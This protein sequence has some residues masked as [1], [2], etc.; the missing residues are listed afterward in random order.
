MASPKESF[1]LNSLTHQNT[2]PVAKDLP[3]LIKTQCNDEYNLVQL[4]PLPTFQDQQCLSLADPWLCERQD[5]DTEEDGGGD[6]GK[7]IIPYPG[8]S[9]S[10]FKF[11]A[12]MFQPGSFSSESDWDVQLVSRLDKLQTSREQ[13]IDIADLRRSCIS[14][15]DSGYESHLCSVLRQKSELEAW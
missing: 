15:R 11:D 4:Q 3:V 5:R 8:V 14:V 13:S 9:N 10:S 2:Q 7:N 1:A 6:V 12:S